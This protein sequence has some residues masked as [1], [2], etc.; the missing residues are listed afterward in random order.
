MPTFLQ[1]ISNAITQGGFLM[2]PFLILACVWLAAVSSEMIRRPFLR[3][4]ATHILFPL[5]FAILALAKVTESFYHLFDTLRISGPMDPLVL[6]QDGLVF[7]R[8]L[9]VLVTAATISFFSTLCILLWKS[10][11]H[12]LLQNRPASENRSP[13]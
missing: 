9:I 8:V 6:A 13:D 7:S 4:P 1:N 11:G 2:I 3:N 12:S 10:R 5:G